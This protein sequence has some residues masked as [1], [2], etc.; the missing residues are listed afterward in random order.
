MFRASYPRRFEDRVTL[1][2]LRGQELLLCSV[3]VTLENQ[4]ES[5]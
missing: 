4:Q 1:T 3:Q 5:P 2:V